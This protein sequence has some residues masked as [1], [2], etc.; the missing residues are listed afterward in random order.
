MN[1]LFFENLIFKIFNETF[2]FDR[3]KR[4]E[5]K[6]N[7]VKRCLKK[8]VSKTINE[9]KHE[10]L[11]DKAPKII[12]QYWH[13]GAENAP[14]L[15][16]ACFKSVEKYMPCY[17]Q[18]ILS[19][20]TIKDY[21]DIPEKYYKLLEQKKIPIAIFSDILRLHLLEKYGGIWLDS[22]IY[23]TNELPREIIDSDFFAFKID[24]ELSF[25]KTSLKCYF[26]KSSSNNMFLKL[27]KKTIENYWNENDF[28]VNYFMFEHIMTMIF[29]LSY[30]AKKIVDKIPYFEKANRGMLCSKLYD[31]FNNNEYEEIIKNNC[32]HKISYKALKNLP[33]K[34]TY[35]EQIINILNN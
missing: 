2:V 22:T 7:W 27:I 25:T 9:Y 17:E 35:Y 12:W 4:T 14:E 23:L 33:T 18:K 16:K 13:Q 11:E 26:I 21:V 15:I 8:Y 32:V 3:K 34:D 28:L 10:N 24:K 5:L 6:T 30:E 29:E 1:F 20:E 19:F 31:K